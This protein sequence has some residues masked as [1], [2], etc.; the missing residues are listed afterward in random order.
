MVTRP[1]LTAGEPGNAGQLGDQYPAPGRLPWEKGEGVS[2][3]KQH[4]LP[5]LSSIASILGLIKLLV[6]LNSHRKS[7]GY[8]PIN[9]SGGVFH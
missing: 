1:Y 8:E 3:H 2:V 9:R 6:N 5:P 4:S 7:T